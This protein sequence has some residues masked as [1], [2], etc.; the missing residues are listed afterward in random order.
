MKE[1]IT[2][3]GIT[4]APGTKSCGWAPVLDTDYKLPVTVINGA[5]DGKTLLLTSSIHGCE[6][7]SIEAVFRIAETIDPMEVSGQIVVINPVNVD[8]F[9]T[10]TPYL[11][12]QDGKN[13]NRLFPGNPNGTLGDKIAYVLTEEYQKR[14]DFYLDTH[15]GDLPEL[16]DSYAYYPTICS[17]EVLEINEHATEYVLNAKYIVGSHATNHAYNYA[18]MIGVPCIML[19]LGCNGSWSEKEVQEYIEN[20]K[21]LMRYLEL[22]PGKAL[23]RIKPIAHIIEGE[24]LD[25]DVTGRWYPSVDKDSEVREGQKLGEIKDLFGNVL[26][27]YYAQM[28]GIVMMVCGALSVQAGDPIISYGMRCMTDGCS[29]FHKD[30]EGH[31]H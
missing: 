20:I 16:Q 6:Y 31:T 25:A 14:A 7:P 9:L 8:G 21:N 28:D 10:R 19:E 12:P 30:E 18:S 24:Y 3:G 23:K 29:C 1:S 17:P 27:E 22:I 2:Y 4:A 26:K 11:V 13:L 5:K 15:G